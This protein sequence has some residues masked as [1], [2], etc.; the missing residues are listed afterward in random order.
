VLHQGVAGSVL[1]ATGPGNFNCS[2]FDVNRKMDK[3]VFSQ[4][5][6]SATI[7]ETKASLS[8]SINSFRSLT[9]KN[10][11]VMAPVMKRCIVLVDVR[12]GEKKMDQTKIKN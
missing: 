8:S 10:W 4:F 12:F 9:T 1:S 2:D 11:C 3:K 7:E 6:I 5:F